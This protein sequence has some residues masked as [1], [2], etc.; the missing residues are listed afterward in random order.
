MQEF[1]SYKYYLEFMRVERHKIHTEI[2]CIEHT[3]TRDTSHLN[4]CCE[5][6]LIPLLEGEVERI[7][8][9]PPTNPIQSLD[10]S[11]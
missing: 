5:I 7:S 9:H 6:Q 11:M 2:V 4:K 10:S 8:Q 3:I 1:I